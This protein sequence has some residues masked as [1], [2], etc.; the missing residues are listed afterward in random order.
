MVDMAKS[1]F[2]IASVALLVALLAAACAGPEFATPTPSQPLAV[3]ATSSPAQEQATAVPA[4]DAGGSGGQGVR[5]LIAAQAST[6]GTAPVKLEI[7]L[8]GASDLYGA[9]VHLTYDPT[10]L[11][12]QDANS[13]QDG[14]QITP[15][16]V[17]AEG[18]S[19]VALNRVD[20]QAGKV[21]FAATLLNPAKPLEG[22]VVLASFEVVGVKA[23]T[24]KVEIAQVLLANREGKSLKVTSQ[25]LDLSA[26]P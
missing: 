10:I 12:V 25:P 7:V 26:K 6:V 24:T 15:G 2:I 21:D 17:F 16:S 1:R 13:N 11:K 22:R 8:D 14:I 4:Q 9:E 23:G 3:A 5:A 18:S 19:F 20:P